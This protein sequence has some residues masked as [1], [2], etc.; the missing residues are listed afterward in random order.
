[1]DYD[2]Q[3]NTSLLTYLIYA[4]GNSWTE[5]HLCCYRCG[6]FVRDIHIGPNTKTASDTPMPLLHS[7]PG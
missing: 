4:Q 7:L 5:I 1:M 6:N 2:K 3:D